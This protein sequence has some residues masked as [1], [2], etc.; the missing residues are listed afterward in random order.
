MSCCVLQTSALESEYPWIA[1][2]R[3]YFGSA[4]GLYDFAGRQ[5]GVAGQRLAMLRERKDKL[6]RG[7]NAR[8]H[9]LL[10]KEEDQVPRRGLGTYFV[11]RCVFD[12]WRCTRILLWCIFPHTAKQ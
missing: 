6:A 9:T 7:L 12:R 3:E 1:S 2:E 10:G 5:A 11:L 4:G 8:A